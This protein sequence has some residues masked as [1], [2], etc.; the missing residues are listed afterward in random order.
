[1]RGLVLPAFCSKTVPLPSACRV[2]ALA[3]CA[4][5]SRP[6]SWQTFRI[7]CRRRRCCL[8]SSSSAAMHPLIPLCSCRLPHL[9]FPPPPTTATTVPARTPQITFTNPFTLPQVRTPTR[10]P[11]TPSHVIS[12]FIS[13]AKWLHRRGKAAFARIWGHGIQHVSNVPI[14][15]VSA[16]STMA[17]PA[18]HPPPRYILLPSLLLNFRRRRPCL[19]ASA[20]SRLLLRLLL[21][22]L[23]LH[24]RLLHIRA[25]A[26][27]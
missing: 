21:L 18:P 25:H 20:P 1:M 3:I 7:T 23:R 27:G 19:A 5:R 11:S 16:T 15:V 2:R 14:V 17:R 6:R 9:P 8:H 24:P 22:L 4:T 12:R 26:L 10:A 13:A